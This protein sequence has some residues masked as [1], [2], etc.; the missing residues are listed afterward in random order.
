MAAVHRPLPC[1]YFA[2]DSDALIGKVDCHLAALCAAPDP[3]DRALA[4]RLAATLRQLIIYTTRASAADRARVRAAVHYFVLGRAARR[5][6][7]PGRG[8]A[9]DVRVVND[10]AVALGRTDLLVDPAAQ[11]A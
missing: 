7:H 8:L 4:E 11:P 2:R 1:D 6:R 10:I 9:D 5:A 3:A